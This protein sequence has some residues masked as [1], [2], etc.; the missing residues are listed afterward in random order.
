MN[1]DVQ[2]RFVRLRARLLI[3]RSVK[4]KSYRLTIK[5]Y[6]RKLLDHRE[7]SSPTRAG[8]DFDQLPGIA[9]AHGFN[10]EGA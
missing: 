9:A 6:A 8:I 1:D 7:D 5:I 3:C 10:V 4:P 2:H